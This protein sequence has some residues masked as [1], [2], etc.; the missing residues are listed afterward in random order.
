MV[1][2]RKLINTCEAL[3]CVQSISMMAKTRKITP[4]LKIIILELC[5]FHLRETQ[6]HRDTLMPV[7]MAS[8]TTTRV[9]GASPES[10]LFFLSY[11]YLFNK[12]RWLTHFQLFA[13]VD[14]RRAGIM[15]PKQEKTCCCNNEWLINLTEKSR[16]FIDRMTLQFLCLWWGPSRGQRYIFK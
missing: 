11:F 13:S 4:R 7:N 12:N 15:Y 3:Q 2:H 16:I 5:L 8:N 10:P 1:E 14:P 6:R 9:H